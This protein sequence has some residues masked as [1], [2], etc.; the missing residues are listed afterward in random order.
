MKTQ[1]RLNFCPVI[2]TVFG[3]VSCGDFTK[4][5]PDPLAFI[6][7][8]YNVA[9]DTFPSSVKVVEVLENVNGNQKHHDALVSL[10]TEDVPAN[11]NQGPVDFIAPELSEFASENDGSLLPPRSP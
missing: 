10:N 5:G 9:C 4:D 8:R 3:V 7:S 11:F 1:L 6:G 2:A